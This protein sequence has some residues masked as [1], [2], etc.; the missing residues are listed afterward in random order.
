MIHLAAYCFSPPSFTG[1]AQYRYDGLPGDG[2][3]WY[4]RKRSSCRDDQ[5]YIAKCSG[6]P[7]QKFQFLKHSGG[8]VQI[9]VASKNLCFESVGN[10]VY[11]RSCDSNEKA[12]R[13]Y[14]PNGDIDGRRFELSQRTRVR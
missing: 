14:A 3:C 13:W 5:I 9:K 8:E 6:D 4:G 10:S 12:Q 1:C 2:K 7:D 11:L